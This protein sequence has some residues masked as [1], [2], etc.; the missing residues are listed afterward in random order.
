MFD[1]NNSITTET[2]NFQD[3]STTV[4]IDEEISKKRNSIGCP[5]NQGVEAVQPGPR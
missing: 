2:D 4:K 3:H 1:N 5:K